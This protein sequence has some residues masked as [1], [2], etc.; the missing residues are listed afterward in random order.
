MTAVKTTL[1]RRRRSALAT[2]LVAAMAAGVAALPAA[3]AGTPLAFAPCTEKAQAGWEC[4]TLTAPLDHAGTTPGTVELRVQRLAHAGPPRAKALVN[5][6]GGPGGA[7]TARSAQTR[8]LLA[9]VTARN[10]YDLVLV[11]LRATGA[12]RPQHIALGTARFYSTAASVRDLELVRAGLGVERL[13]IMGTSYSTLTAAEY[14][15]T[16][17]DRADRLVLDSPM[18][19]DGPTAF[20]TETAA[21]ALP[22]LD[23]V[24]RRSRCPG[25][26]A[27]L[28]RDVAAIVARARRGLFWVPSSYVWRRGGGPRRER[29]EVGM[30]PATLLTQIAPADEHTAAFAQLPAALHD[31]ARGDYRMLT[32]ELAFGTA[33]ETTPP[34]NPEVNRATRCIDLRTPWTFEAPLEQRKA[35]TEALQRT[36]SPSTL[37]PWGTAPLKYGTVWDCTSFAPSGMPE[38]IRGGEIPAGVPG[39]ILQGAWDM[40]TPPAN[41][42]AVAARWKSGTVV[43][44]P[45]TGHGV[46]RSATPCATQA[47]DALLSGRAVDAGACSGTRPVA[48]PQL[49]GARAA[50]VAALPGAPR[51]VARTA[52][53][54]L[55]T[56]RDAE[57]T[58]AVA[59]PRGGSALV[60]G[61]ADG[62]AE[63]TRTAPS[64]ASTLR[65]TRF[66]LQDGL[67]LAGTVTIRSASSYGARL[68]LGGRHR[69]TVA[70]AGGR[71][72]GKI[73]GTKLDV[74][75]RGAH[76]RPAVTRYG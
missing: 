14:A 50:D 53:A 37:A 55:A 52:A 44:A 76:A 2:A 39:V 12:S 16:F 8:R 19:P 41:A 32:R 33:R 42:R 7:T 67:Q 9:D 70:I 15:R 23:D 22:A 48:E 46:L 43:T 47:L 49:I 26:V 56:I 20:G 35:A 62:W 4:A 58:I 74:R 71:L 72:R 10:G 65:L 18:G 75:L 28:R 25:G 66:A 40:R 21:A 30:R 31:A 59:A 54:V 17:P 73:D 13:A 6:E 57:V 68:T 45:G 11:D 64:L 51:A 38:A 61:V 63:A 27:G 24:C 1:R 3:A 34:V 60:P 36:I 29:S 69:G 5:L